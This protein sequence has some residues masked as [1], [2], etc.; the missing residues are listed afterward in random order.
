M[1][2]GAESPILFAT[3]F[4]PLAIMAN[5]DGRHRRAARLL[6]ALKMM[7]EHAGGSAPE[8]VI[9][10]FGDPEPDARAALGDEEFEQAR[11]EGYAATVDEAVA[12]ALEID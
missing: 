2:A 10:F 1:S 4:L 9:A 6:G 12:L 11:A 3:A 7:N 8:V 5:H